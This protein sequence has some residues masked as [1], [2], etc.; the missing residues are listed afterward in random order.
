MIKYKNVFMTGLLVTLLASPFTGEA[1][2]AAE[3]AKKEVAEQSKDAMP[4][5][6]LKDSGGKEVTNASIKGRPTVFVLMQTACNICRTEVADVNTIYKSGKY[7]NMQFYIVN[8]D[9]S[10]KLLPLYLKDNEISIPVLFDPT[11]SMGKSIGATVTPAMI[12]VAKDGR[13]KAVTTGY[14]EG[15][16]EEMSKNLESIK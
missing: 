2:F 6:S 3:E 1:V 7:K 15:A 11:F 12:F 16:F 8:V 10:P 14:A 13:V 4:T 9:V 5:F